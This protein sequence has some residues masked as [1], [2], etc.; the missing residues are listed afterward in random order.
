[1]IDKLTDILNQIVKD[2]KFG[3]IEFFYQQIR[4]APDKYSI[5]KVGDRVE[6]RILGEQD[7]PRI[8]KVLTYV[9]NEF[10]NINND[11][12]K[13]KYPE[14]KTELSSG[15]VEQVEEVS[16]RREKIEVKVGRYLIQKI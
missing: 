7:I 16:T 9:D 5:I 10:Y 6:S 2:N 3:F 15:I 4:K 14:L 8:G 11:D 1:M 13:A 12:Y